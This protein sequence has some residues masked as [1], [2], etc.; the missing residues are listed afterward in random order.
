MQQAAQANPAAYAAQ[1]A[2]YASQGMREDAYN[3]APPQE[4]QQEVQV[5]SA[6]H[7]MLGCVCAVLVVH[8]A[9]S[10]AEVPGSSSSLV[11]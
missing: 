4:Y 5:C 3:Q 9:K 11:L 10:R 6:A 8:P 1:Y 2:A 7:C